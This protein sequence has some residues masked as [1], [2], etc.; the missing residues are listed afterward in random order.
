MVFSSTIFLCAFLPTVLLLYYISPLGC[1]KNAVL[2]LASLLFYAWGEPKLVILMVLSV[3]GN[4][5]FG[6]IIHHQ[7]GKAK[8][9]TFAL[10]LSLLFNLGLLFYF[11]Y[12]NFIAQSLSSIL[13]KDWNIIAIALPIGISFYTFQ[14]LSYVIDVY[15]EDISSPET[16]MVQKNPASLALY[17]SMFPQLIAGPIV[18][19]SDIKPYLKKRRHSLEQFCDG[20]EFFIRGL[21]KKVIFANI[22]GEVATSLMETNAAAISSGEAWLGAVCYTLQI[23][24]DFC[25]YSEMAIGLGKMF[26]FEFMRNFNY[27]YISRSITEFW[28]RWHISL[29][30]WFR[31]YLYIPLGGNRKGNVYFNLFIVFLATGIWHGAAWGFIIWG[32]WHGAFMLIERIIKKHSKAK[33]EKSLPKVLTAPL[34]WAYTMLIVILGWVLFRIVAV[35]DTLDFIKIM[36]GLESCEYVRYDILWY[37]NSRT[38][39]V[40]AVALFCC[41]PWKSI[42]ISRFARAQDFFAHP[43]TVA[44][45][46]VFLIVLLV[47]CFLLITN[48]TYNPFIYFRF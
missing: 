44:L 43:I 9:G 14:G 45:K 2:L 10:V 8:K 26:G 32:L 33:S 12:F 25:G 11:K 19:Y 21:A 1:I 34:G 46:R 17:I 42:L 13:G 29:S 24:Y 7:H 36:F 20:I 6:I 40:L 23:F 18:R 39:T 16:V 30:S 47:V 38:L 41:I 22:L 31:D 28:R 5:L 4:Y 35:S 48:S 3:L 15:R 27:P 37:L